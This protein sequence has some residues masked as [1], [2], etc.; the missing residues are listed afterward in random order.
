MGIPLLDNWKE[1]Y[2]P[3]QARVYPVGQ[4]VDAL[5][6]STAAEKLTAISKLAFLRNLRQLETYLGIT[7]VLRQYIPYYAAII[8]PLQLRKTALNRTLR[9]SSTGGNARRK[10][11]ARLCVSA[12]R[13]FRYLQSLFSRPSMLVH[14]DSKRQMYIDMDGSKARAHGAYAYHVSEESKPRNPTDPPGAK[15]I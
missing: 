5:G 3:G 14:H 11:V 9:E 12:L 8:K 1:L 10:L 6:L 2:K 4:P 15:S 13:A 7:G